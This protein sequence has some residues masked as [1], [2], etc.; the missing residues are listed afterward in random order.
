MHGETLNQT[1]QHFELVYFQLNL[2][3]IFFDLEFPQLG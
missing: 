2:L 1:K 3:V